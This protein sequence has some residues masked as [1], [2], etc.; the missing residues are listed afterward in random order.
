[1]M[2]PRMHP[3][4]GA[5]A[6]IVSSSGVI[7]NE[8]VMETERYTGLLPASCPVRGHPSGDDAGCPP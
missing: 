6:G 5:Y 2:N 4:I 3:H 7:G 1:M 8:I